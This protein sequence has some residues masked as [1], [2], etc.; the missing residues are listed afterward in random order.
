[1]SDL[2]PCPLCG[3]KAVIGQAEDDRFQVLCLNKNCYLL[4]PSREEERNAI[5]AW[6]RR[7]AINGAQLD[8]LAAELHLAAGS[9]PGAPHAALMIFA[10]DRITALEAE[11]ARLT[12]AA[13]NRYSDTVAHY[14]SIE[15]ENAR[16]REAL[17]TAGEKGAQIM[18]EAHQALAA[19]E[20]A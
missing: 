16:L 17:T 18:L 14:A 3:S 5:A 19:R 8:G 6:N 20:D 12:T 1:M 7:P 11:V 9:D 4:G 2:L 15:A 13:E 10:A